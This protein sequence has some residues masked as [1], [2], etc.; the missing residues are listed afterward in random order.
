MLLVFYKLESAYEN[1]KF[2]K[3]SFSF[4]VFVNHVF[5]HF[6]MLACPNVFNLC[7]WCCFFLI[8][9]PR[10][11]CNRIGPI[12]I[13]SQRMTLIHEK[14]YFLYCSARGGMI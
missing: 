6:A 7:K 14:S 5:L 4:F 2:T 9:E 8:N 12:A 13:N 1:G 3:L 10:P 11:W